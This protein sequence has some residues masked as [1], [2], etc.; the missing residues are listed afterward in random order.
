MGRS[1][2]SGADIRSFRHSASGKKQLAQQPRSVQAAPEKK[3]KPKRAGGTKNLEKEVAAAERA[4]AKAEEKMAELEQS[5]QD[6]A[7]D[8]VALQEL[9]QQ[10]EQLQNEL[11]GLYSS[12]ER[13][14]AQ[15][16]EARG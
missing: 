7:A 9:Y 3:E 15:L 11:T 16:E 13:L 12:W 5:I 6:A 14:A 2:I 8:Y 10:Q 4:I 1:P